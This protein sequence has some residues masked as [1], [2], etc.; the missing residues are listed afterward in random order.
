MKAVLGIGVISP[1]ES[2]AGIA[3][4]V[5]LLFWLYTL[6]VL[7]AGDIKLFC[8]IGSFVGVEIWKIICLSMIFGAVWG[9]VMVVRRIYRCAKAGNGM[10]IL[11]E[12]LTKICFSVPI[13]LG[14]LVYIFREVLSGGIQAWNM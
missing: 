14:L 13:A 3:I 6:R 1:F 4:P 11:T 8:A 12:K 5:I 9:F 10:G 2:L 7:G